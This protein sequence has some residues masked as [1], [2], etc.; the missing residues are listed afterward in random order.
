MVL[1]LESYIYIMCVHLLVW[2]LSMKFLLY[3]GIPPSVEKI[4]FYMTIVTDTFAAAVK[5]S[6][7]MSL[8]LVSVELL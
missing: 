6:N 3:C 1:C 8:I 4:Q 5:P 7:L 2:Q